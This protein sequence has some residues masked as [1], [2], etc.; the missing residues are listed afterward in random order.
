M[1]FFL[2]RFWFG[3]KTR[4]LASNANIADNCDNHF[5]KLHS[6]PVLKSEVAA[7]LALVADHTERNMR[8]L[9]A[10]HQQ[11]KNIIGRFPTTNTGNASSSSHEREGPQSRQITEETA[12]ADL[13]K[14]IS[15]RELRET[16]AV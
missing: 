16:I 9:D 3:E 4:K 14:V 11:T 7:P 6:A 13:T 2:F 8:L 5:A 15:S 10:Q 1:S 12:G